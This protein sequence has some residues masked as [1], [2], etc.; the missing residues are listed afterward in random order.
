MG[1]RVFGGEPC[2]AGLFL[3]DLWL[4]PALDA[5]GVGVAQ[6]ACYPGEE[7]PERRPALGFLAITDHHKMLDQDGHGGWLL[8]R[9]PRAPLKGLAQFWL[10][11]LRRER[12]QAIADLARQ[13]HALRATGRDVDRHRWA[14]HIIQA[15]LLQRIEEVLR[16]GQF[17]R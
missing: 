14:G 1:M 16:A 3:G 9:G 17:A 5:A 13:S 2:V 15:S 8:P 11:C 7:A 6:I 12:D 10:T 4:G